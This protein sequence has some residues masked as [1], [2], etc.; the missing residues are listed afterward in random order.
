MAAYHWQHF[1]VQLSDLSHDLLLPFLLLL[2]TNQQ[3]RL[4]TAVF[5]REVGVVGPWFDPIYALNG[6]ATTGSLV[7]GET[8]LARNIVFPISWGVRTRLRQLIVSRPAFFPDVNAGLPWVELQLF[9]HTTSID[10]PMC[11]SLTL[12]DQLI[13]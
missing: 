13:H 5:L 10:L 8:Y 11:Y 2:A 9:L 12:S 6:R 7:R 1:V 3:N 4:D